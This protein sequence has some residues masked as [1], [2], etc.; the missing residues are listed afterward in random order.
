MGFVQKLAKRKIKSKVE[1]PMHIIKDNTLYVKVI[2][3]KTISYYINPK[4]WIKWL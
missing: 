1:I 4:N 2:P 3:K